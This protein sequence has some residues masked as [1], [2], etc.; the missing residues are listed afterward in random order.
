M[1]VPLQFP[2]AFP[3]AHRIYN[4]SKF[5]D[6]DGLGISKWCLN[7]YDQLLNDLAN[8]LFPSNLLYHSIKCSVYILGMSSMVI[9]QPW[10]DLMINNFAVMGYFL[11]TGRLTQLL[12]NVSGYNSQ[13]ALKY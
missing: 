7:P 1:K 6:I 4:T 8:I 2:E 11:L 12:L 3:S 10:F 13:F 5:V 9:F